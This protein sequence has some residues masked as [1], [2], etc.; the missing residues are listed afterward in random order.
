M[1]RV[2][3]KLRATLEAHLDESGRVALPAAIWVAEARRP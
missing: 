2:T 3:D 1:Q